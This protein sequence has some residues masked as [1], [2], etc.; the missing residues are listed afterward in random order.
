MTRRIRRS[1]TLA[2]VAGRARVAVMTACRALNNDPSVR[3]NNRERVLKAAA[4]LN[5]APSVFARCLKKQVSDF[6]LVSLWHIANPFFGGLAE[7]ISLHLRQ[8]GLEPVLCDSTRKVLELHQALRPCGCLLNR[9][10]PDIVASL[11][12]STAIV[13]MNG[14]SQTAQVP[15]VTIDFKAAYTAIARELVQGGRKRIAY[16]IEPHERGSNWQRKF[17]HVQSLLAEN[18]LR[19]G[20]EFG[21]IRELLEVFSLKRSRPQAVFCQNDPFAVKVLWALQQHGVRCPEDVIVIG[22]DGSMVLD[23]MWS[24]DVSCE[25]FARQLVDLL[26]GCIGGRRHA[27]RIMLQPRVITGSPATSNPHN[28]PRRRPRRALA[29]A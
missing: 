13:T 15:D 4:E 2:D 16:C 23:G 20:R 8:E 3:R 9:P 22:C 24:V 21:S 11:G 27:R 12:Q 25:E 7:A 1:P 28:R 19:P 17:R 18:K 6:V 29:V 26:R 10:E 5:Y 14:L